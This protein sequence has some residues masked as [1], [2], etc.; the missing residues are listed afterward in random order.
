M[1]KIIVSENILYAVL[2]TYGAGIIIDE[3]KGLSEQ[4]IAR[5]FFKILKEY[6]E[7]HHEAK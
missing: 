2:K 5:R 1:E 4:E 6:Q 3:W 7:K